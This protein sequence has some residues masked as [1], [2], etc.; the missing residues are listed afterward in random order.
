MIK[1]Y[2]IYAIK[3]FGFREGI[4]RTIGH[5]GFIFSY[6][7]PQKIID[8][9]KRDRRKKSSGTTKYAINRDGDL[10]L[11]ECP[12]CHRQHVWY[13]KGKK[14]F[15]CYKCRIIFSVYREDGVV[16]LVDFRKGDIQYFPRT[17]YREFYP[18]HL[19]VLGIEGDAPW[20]WGKKAI[21]R[22][23]HDGMDAHRHRAYKIMERTK[24]SSPQTTEDTVSPKGE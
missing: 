1:I 5:I 8:F 21:Y 13:E 14:G 10:F 2:A 12:E 3:R 7:I 15:E 23:L 9:K 17:A 18:D 4:K 22:D 19:Y 24:E 16:K 20:W 11:V 6:E